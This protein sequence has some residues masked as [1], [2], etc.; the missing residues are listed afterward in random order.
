MATH[1]PDPSVSFNR[2]PYR[3]N[4]NSDESKFRIPYFNGKS[5]FEGFW[6]V[7]ELG[8]K[9][10]QWNNQSKIENLWCCLKDDALDF[11]CK[12]SPDVQNNI[13]QFRDALQRRYGDNRLPEQYRENLANLKKHFKE[14]LPEYAARVEN[15]VCRGYPHLK[16]FNLLNTLKV[17][18]FLKGLPD[19]SIAYEV[20]IR[21]PQSIDDAIEWLN[22]HECCIGNIFKKRAEVSRIETDVYYEHTELIEEN[23]IRK[24]G[25][26]RFVTEERLY[27]KLE[28]FSLEIKTEFSAIENY[29]KGE[30]NL[31]EPDGQVLALPVILDELKENK[32][33]IEENE[34]HKC[35][36]NRGIT[37]DFNLTNSGNK[38]NTK[39]CR[40]IDIGKSKLS[41][42]FDDTDKLYAVDNVCGDESDRSKLSVASGQF[43]D[44]EIN[45]SG[46]SFLD[47][48]VTVDPSVDMTIVDVVIDRVRAVTLRVPIV[49]E[50]DFLNAVIDTGAEVTV[51][52]QEKFLKIP[53]NRRPQIYRAERNLVVAE[54]GKKMQTLGGQIKLQELFLKEAVTIPANS[55]V[56]LPGLSINS[57]ILDS[58][59]CSVEPVV[60]DERKIIVARSLVDPYKETF[61]VR[62]VNVE[63]YPIRIR[64]NYL[65]GELHPVE[66]LEVFIDNNADVE[67]YDS[68]LYKDFCI[69]MS[70]G[71][72]IDTP[73]IPESWRSP[74]VLSTK[75]DSFEIEAEIPKLPDF[76]SE[77]YQKSCE[78][79]SDQE[80][81]LKLAKVLLKNQGAF[82]KDKLDLGSCSLIK[83]KIDTAGAA[84]TRQPLR[85]TP[86]NFEGEEEAY[87]KDQLERGVIKPSSSAWRSNICLVRK[88]DGLVR[89]CIDYRKLNESTIKDAYPIP[90]ISMCLDCLAGA[91]IFSVMDLQSGYWRLEMA[92]EDRHKTAFI[93]KYGLFEYT[94]MISDCVMLLQHFKD[95]VRNPE[96]KNCKSMDADWVDFKTDVDNVTNLSDNPFVAKIC[97]VTRSQNSKLIDSNWLSGYTTK[98]LENFQ[99]EDIETYVSKLKSKLEEIYQLAREN[100]R[101]SAVRQ[102]KDYDTRISQNQFCKGSLVYKFNSIFKKLNE[103]WSGPFVVVDVLSPVLYKIKNRYKSETVHHDKLKKYQSNDVPAWAVAVQKRM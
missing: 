89:W 96:C 15:L 94:K 64:K 36:L 28:I 30:I 78:K 4:N 54:A 43:D 86:T 82:A 75:T 91:S 8:T 53:E 102:K 22:W 57:E 50:G 5:K 17:E 9:K 62:I 18:N 88:K 87:L 12:L 93:T 85:R 10:F 70:Q 58:R 74:K 32:F 76:L 40:D 101:S 41:V 103:R 3:N 49:I 65:L 21:K 69:G 13:S 2:G 38:R 72:L 81:K 59:Y 77:L 7:F 61:P 90:N 55:E 56:I 66:Q 83:H 46:S 80:Q 20:K 19:Q 79:I 44:A 99:R 16:E 25:N 39:V 92:P 48:Y 47:E 33:I 42:S 52:S 67:L 68:V 29:L 98:E 97:A 100:L 23:E 31:V 26:T 34:D 11:A 6:T 37:V 63:K 1:M 60:E 71:D 35:K 95:G 51:M 45:I 84:P 73:V 27:K 14:T 24:V